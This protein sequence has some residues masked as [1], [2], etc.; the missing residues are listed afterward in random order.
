M[1]IG[2]SAYLDHWRPSIN[3]NVLHLNKLRPSPTVQKKTGKVVYPPSGVQHEVEH[4]TNEVTR[5]WRDFVGD[6]NMSR[7]GSLSE[8][9]DNEARRHAERVRGRLAQ[10][11]GVSEARIPWR[12]P[13]K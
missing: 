3:S 1:K 9:I 5:L 8:H 7:Y 4:L 13:P 10:I 12:P 11:L 2:A 6:S